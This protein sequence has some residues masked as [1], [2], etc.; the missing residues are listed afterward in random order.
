MS[1]EYPRLEQDFYDKLIWQLRGQL[2][3]IFYPLRRY[4]QDV[5]VDGAIEETIEVAE[6]FG[7][8]VRGKNAPVI[9]R[10]KRNPR[11]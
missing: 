11:D 1:E 7:E 5:Y 10:N 2:N 3:D 6:R 8:A 4:G 9:L